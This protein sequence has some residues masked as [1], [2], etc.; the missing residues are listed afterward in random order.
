VKFLAFICFFMIVCLVTTIMALRS[1][2]LVVTTQDIC[3]HYCERTGHT[4]RSSGFNLKTS[5]IECGCGKLV[6]PKD[7][8]SKT[9]R[10]EQ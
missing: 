5:E 1:T 4:F 8:T 7:A 6:L 10:V 2:K 3:T 9:I